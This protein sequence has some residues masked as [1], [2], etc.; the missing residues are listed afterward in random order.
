MEK[1][2]FE[3]DK[4]QRSVRIR[5]ATAA[6]VF[7]SA[8]MTV[9]IALWPSFPARNNTA[10]DRATHSASMIEGVVKKLE[11]DI[12]LLLKENLEIRKQLKSYSD[13]PHEANT[14][15]AYVS[16]KTKINIID[17]RLGAIERAIM[18]S[19]ERSLSIPLI[20]KDLDQN[21]K[22]INQTH[23]ILK[24]EIDRLYE[25]GRWI[26]GGIGTILIGVITSALGFM[27]KLIS[28]KDKQG[29]VG[30]KST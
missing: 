13:L 19:P 20:R 29:H 4:A 21:E 24:A 18:D 6:L 23:G 9:I 8:G 28:S 7:G 10:L 1:D 14:R 11:T 2:N 12:A 25:Y 3:R 26:L 16:L 17:E 22:R 27:I 5:I 30:V 15:S